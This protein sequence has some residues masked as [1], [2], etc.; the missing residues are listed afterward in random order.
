MGVMMMMMQVAWVDVMIMKGGGD[1]VW[2][3]GGYSVCLR[4]T[5]MCKSATELK[6]R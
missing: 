5:Q 4:V 6:N 3:V 1:E 2:A